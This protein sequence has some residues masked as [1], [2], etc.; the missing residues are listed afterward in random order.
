M[1]IIDVLK[2]TQWQAPLLEKIQKIQ[3]VDHHNSG[4]Y[5][6]FE[7]RLLEYDCFT[8]LLENDNIVA[9]SGLYNNGIF[10]K[11]TIRAL[12]RTYY[13][14][15]Q[16]KSVNQRY[17]SQYFWPYHVKLAQELGY[18]SVFFSVQNIK[19]RRALLDTA[20]RC[21]PTPTVLTTMGN[22]CRVI[23]GEINQDVLCWQN[24]AVYKFNNDEFMLPTQELPDHRQQYANIKI[25]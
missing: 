7:T 5:N 17:A 8:I 16:N 4:N 6:N 18:S 22:T 24:I 15:W 25:R 19:K 14:N 21:H 11:N 13:F 3:H 23:N 2:V 1:K 20:R 10:P 9:M 12:D